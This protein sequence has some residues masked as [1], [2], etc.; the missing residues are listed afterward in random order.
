[1]IITCPNCEKKFEVDSN[2][3]PEKG[4]LVKCG[5]CDQTWFFNKNSQVNIDNKNIDLS[6]KNVTK[7]TSS[8]SVNKKEKTSDKDTPIISKNNKGSELIKYQTKSNFTFGKILNYLIVTIVS[9]VALIIILDT[10]KG[11]LNVFFPN[12]ELI[13]YNLFET[14]KDLLLFIKD[15]N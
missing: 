15:L 4:R 14:L 3:I 1:M 2:I 5:T 11:P 13:L 8:K 7:K 6:I 10:F 12:L 9:F